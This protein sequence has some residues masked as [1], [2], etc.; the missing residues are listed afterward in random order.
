MTQKPKKKKTASKKAPAKNKS[1]PLEPGSPLPEIN[2]PASVRELRDAWLRYFTEKNHKHIPSASLIPAGDPT[3]LFTTAG[4]VQFKPYFAGSEEPSFKRA[5]SI[6]KCF[7]TTDLE[8]VGKTA[9]HL[10]MFEML[11]NFS[12]FSDYFKKEAIEFSWEFSREVLG[13]PEDKIYITVYQDDD[14]AEQIWNKQIGIPLERIKRMDEKDNWW[15]PAGETGPCGPCSE[16]YLDRGEKY[17]TCEDKSEC[18]VGGECDRYMEY[19]NLVFNQYHKDASGKLHPL[20]HKGID[21]GAGL[22]RI[23]S[24]L[25]DCDSVY[26]TDELKSIIHEIEALTGELRE[27]KKEVR[28]EIDSTTP[29]RVLADHSRSVAFAIADGILPDNTGRGYV[30]R[31]IIRR[32]LLFARELGIHSPL[33]YRLIPAVSSIYKDY[34]PELAR[35]PD[36]IAKRVKGEEERFLRTLDMGLKIWEEYLQEHRTSNRK[37]FDGAKAFRLYD[38]FGFPLEMTI[39]LAEK[40]GMQVDLDEFEKHMEHQRE[41]ASSASAFKDFHFPDEFSVDP[42]IPTEFAGYDQYESKSTVIALLEDGREVDALTPGKESIVILNRT[43]FYGESGGQMGDT[44]VLETHDGSVF[45]VKDT[46][47]KNGITLHMGELTSGTIKKTDSVVAR[48]D[49]DRREN[50]TA[51][52][53]ATHLLNAA[54]RKYLGDHVIQTGSLVAPD[55]LRF[56]FSHSERIDRD[57]LKKIQAEVNQSIQKNAPVEA[58]IMPIEE[59][60]SAGAVATFGEK[61]GETVRVVRMGGDDTISNEL[62]GGCHVT[63]TSAIELFRILKEGSPGAGNR[64]IEALA[65]DRVR[66]SYEN[67][68]DTI[69]GQIARYT[70]KLQR[71][72]GDDR[73][74]IASLQIQSVLPDRNAIAQHLRSPQGVEVLDGMIQKIKEELSDKEKELIKAERMK[75]DQKALQAM[76]DLDDLIQKAKPAGRF[77]SIQHIFE[78]LDARG[79]KKIT[80]TLQDKTRDTVLLLGARKSDQAFLLFTAPKSTTALSVHCGN[81][82]KEVAPLIGGGGGGKPELAQAGGKNPDGLEKAIEKAGEILFTVAK[83]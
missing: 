14:E 33:L 42:T 39:E 26:E 62:C 43:P 52:H 49:S 81:L 58:T 1:V 57:V 45:L 22:E 20:P 9:R 82:I 28:Y 48:I 71:E 2:R 35:D 30:I 10:T 69:G 59:A 38:T 68:V 70:E 8:S 55:Y 18:T 76:E 37:I 21:T 64:R 24:L 12:F 27:D 66:R 79:L 73:Q 67:E 51:H 5:V 77:Q 15:G 36:S 75:E 34:Y 46:Q 16:L 4:M 60:K 41:M 72:M 6:Q 74:S 13:F 23:M 32:G 83:Q 65:G 29:F 31:R 53:S 47:K 61:Y 11:G 17:C 50:L 80:E 7:R 40:E 44:G 63:N 54:L 3:L 56:D 25:L 19:W 78:G